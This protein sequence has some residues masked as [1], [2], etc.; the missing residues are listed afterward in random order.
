MKDNLADA[1]FSDFT[2]CLDNEAT[3]LIRASLTE[4]HQEAVRAFIAKRQPA[5][6][7]R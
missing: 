6:R 2:T 4:D 1:L 3:R 5:F 7:G